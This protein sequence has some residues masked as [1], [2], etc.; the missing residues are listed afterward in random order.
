MKSEMVYHHNFAAR[1]EARLAVFE[2]I[3]SFYNRKRRHSALGY[4]TPCQ[5][6]SLLYNQA[7]AAYRNPPVKHC[8]SRRSLAVSMWGARKPWW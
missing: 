2:Y 4:V 7:V 1:Q 5:Y 3:E 8:I 6:E